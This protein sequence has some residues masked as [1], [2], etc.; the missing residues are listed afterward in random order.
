MSTKRVNIYHFINEDCLNLN[1]VQ[2]NLAFNPQKKSDNNDWFCVIIS[3]EKIAHG[4]KEFPPLI[5]DIE[6]K[7]SDNKTTNKR[8]LVIVNCLICT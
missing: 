4:E 8:F 5:F 3:I 7:N 1:K 6:T 2:L